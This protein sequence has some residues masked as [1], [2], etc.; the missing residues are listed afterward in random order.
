[1]GHLHSKTRLSGSR[2]PTFDIYCGRQALFHLTPNTCSKNEAEMCLVGLSEPKGKQDTGVVNRSNE[3]MMHVYPPRPVPVWLTHSKSLPKSQAYTILPTTR[4]IPPLYALH[5]HT[6]QQ[7][8][9]PAPQAC[10]IFTLLHASNTR[11]TSF[12]WCYPEK[13]RKPNTMAHPGKASSY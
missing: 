13:G 9:Q 3:D 2:F 4:S 5:M 8:T 6:C 7:R 1:M 10:S 11:E 12:R